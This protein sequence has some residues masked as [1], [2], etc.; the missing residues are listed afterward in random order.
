MFLSSALNG[1]MLCRS[2]GFV[3]ECSL[4]VFIG[5]LANRSNGSP[6]GNTASCPCGIDTNPNKALLTMRW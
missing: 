5:S 4:L 2:G 6:D 1:C 3:G